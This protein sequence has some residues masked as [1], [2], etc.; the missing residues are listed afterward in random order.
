M[1]H[2]RSATAA[3]MLTHPADHFDEMGFASCIAIT[4]RSTTA[5]TAP[6]PHCVCA[7]GGVGTAECEYATPQGIFFDRHQ[8]C[9]LTFTAP[10]GISGMASPARLPTLMT[11]LSGTL[12]SGKKHACLTDTQLP[13]DLLGG[14][15][16]GTH[17]TV[18]S[19]AVRQAA[20]PAA[21]CPSRAG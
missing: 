2:I 4:H 11:Q 10:S 7:A 12:L 3:C 16:S 1:Q 6:S 17:T 15:A 20:I 13:A 9:S 18:L 14:S 21:D 8:T 19:L 5:Q